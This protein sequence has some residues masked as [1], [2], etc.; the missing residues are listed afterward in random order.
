MSELEDTLI[1]CFAEGNGP[2]FNIP[3]AGFFVCGAAEIY[4]NASPKDLA[5]LINKKKKEI[6]CPFLTTTYMYID[7]S[8]KHCIYLICDF[9]FENDKCIY[10][11]SIMQ[12]SSLENP[13]ECGECKGYDIF[14]QKYLT[15]NNF[16]EKLNKI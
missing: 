16:P 14:C 13:D 6:N 15:K 8:Y 11:N 10:H 2:L 7:P 9:D 3:D 4:F 1:K 5:K 12:G